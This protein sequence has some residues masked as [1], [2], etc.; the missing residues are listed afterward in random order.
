[1]GLTFLHSPFAR[2]NSLIPS[3]FARAHFYFSL[4]HDA[5]GQKGR[6]VGGSKLEGN[7]T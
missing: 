7:T 6:I 3:R 5:G 2:E 4:S 1:M